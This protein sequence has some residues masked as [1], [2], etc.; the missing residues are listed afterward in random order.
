MNKTM[1]TGELKLYL[2]VIKVIHI[3][4]PTNGRIAG[5][6]IRPTNLNLSQPTLTG[7]ASMSGNLTPVT[8][9]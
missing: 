8:I 3:S 2:R 7:N 4:G 5:P 9:L 6:V 1:E